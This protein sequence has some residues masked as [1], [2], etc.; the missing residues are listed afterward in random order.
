M[1]GNNYDVPNGL[2]GLERNVFLKLAAEK[3]HSDKDSWHLFRIGQRPYKWRNHWLFNL[4]KI[5]KEDKDIG[6]I[7]PEDHG[8][9]SPDPFNNPFNDPPPPP[10]PP[11][12][13]FV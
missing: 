5:P 3:H 8:D 7:K 12:A 4:R 1:L 9:N 6:M 13:P 2:Y 10:P 11:P